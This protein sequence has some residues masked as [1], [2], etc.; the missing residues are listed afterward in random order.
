MKTEKALRLKFVCE[1]CSALKKRDNCLRC[2]I[3]DDDFV[4]T[5]QFYKKYVSLRCLKILIY[6]L[7]YESC[8]KED[9]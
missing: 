9:K 6:T 8:W 3:D 2:D 5:K 1:R 7:Y 4:E